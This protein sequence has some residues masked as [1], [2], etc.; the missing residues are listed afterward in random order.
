M[1]STAATVLVGLKVHVIHLHSDVL[2]VVPQDVF[3]G[4]YEVVS[5][6]V[7]V[8]DVV[9]LGSSPRLASVH[10]TGDRDAAV[11]RHQ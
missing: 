10:Q 11:L 8:D 4:G 2:Q 1:F 9:P 3:D 6:P 5:A 7:S